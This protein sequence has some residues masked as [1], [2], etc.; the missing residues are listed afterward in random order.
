MKNRLQVLIDKIKV[1]EA[2]L[3][4]EIQK[5]QDEFYYQFQQGKIVFDQAV[6][7]KHRLLVKTLA[8][9]LSDAAFLNILTAP[10][11]WF[12][13]IPALFLDLS[14]SLFQSI[15]F[16]VYG[17]PKVR[18]ADFIIMDRHALPYLNVIEKFNC[19]YC[20]YFNGLIAYVTEIAA[21]TEQYWCPIKHARRVAAIHSRYGKFLEYGDAAGYRENLEAIRKNYEDIDKS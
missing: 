2:E 19:V 21:R 11:I 13:L 18:R 17:I 3:A 6:I 12:C 14:V 4:E 10:L 20:G 8:P 5:K 16:P 1:L 15:C 7:L 9:Y